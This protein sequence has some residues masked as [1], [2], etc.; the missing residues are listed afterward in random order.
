MGTYR[1]CVD[2]PDAE[3]LLNFVENCNAFQL[4][5]SPA[6]A[7]KMDSLHE[8]VGGESPHKF[9]LRNLREDGAFLA[10]REVCTTEAVLEK[11][12]RVEWDTDDEEVELPELVLVPAH[13]EDGRISDWLSD[14]HGW[15]VQSWK[16]ESRYE[17]QRK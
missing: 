11:R 14:R 9:I 4:T 1:L 5:A 3:S 6:G 15:L 8:K 2:F 10:L 12:V 7:M 16:E 17:L 13:I